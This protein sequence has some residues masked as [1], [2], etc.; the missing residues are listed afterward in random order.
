MISSQIVCFFT[1]QHELSLYLTTQAQSH[2]ILTMLFTTNLQ[3][4]P[5]TVEIGHD[6]A[7]THNCVD[8]VEPVLE[9]KTVAEN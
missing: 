3:L 9:A 2:E 1:S 6:S 4:H 8:R 5:K 7:T